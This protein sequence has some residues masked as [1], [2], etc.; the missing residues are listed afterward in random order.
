MKHHILFSGFDLTSAIVM[1]T[2]LTAQPLPGVQ[3]VQA[4]RKK[5]RA[6]KLNNNNAARE[7]ERTSCRRPFLFFSR[8]VFHA[9][10]QLTEALEELL[11]FF[12]TPLFA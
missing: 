4:Q 10:T 5:R 7:S 12:R 11:L 2:Y 3:L 6:K 8:P 1:H 9:A